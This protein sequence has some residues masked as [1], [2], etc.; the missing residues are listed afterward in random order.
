MDTNIVP[1]IDN[2]KLSNLLFCSWNSSSVSAPLSFNLPNF[3]N[4]DNRSSLPLLLEGCGDEL[5]FVDRV[6]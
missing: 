4:L 1:V 6:I 3:S 2:Y 5:F